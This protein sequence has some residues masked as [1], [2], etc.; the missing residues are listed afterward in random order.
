M[1]A[2]QLT[3]RAG[4]CQHSHAR[5]GVTCKLVDGWQ[6]LA[7]GSQLAAGKIRT[8][9]PTSRPVP[10]AALAPQAVRLARG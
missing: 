2:R 9:E 5:C 6:P 10:H 8:S 1:A 4:S 7:T 3:C